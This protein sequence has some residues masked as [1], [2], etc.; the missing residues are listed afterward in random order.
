MP[1]IK[2]EIKHY[3]ATGNLRKQ[4]II[5]FQLSTV[6]AVVN[7]WHEALDVVVVRSRNK[8]GH[9]QTLRLVNGLR[10]QPDAATT[11]YDISNDVMH[12]ELTYF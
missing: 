4:L 1:N 3:Y 7:Q 9:T 11:R 10:R 5:A 8:V 12:P 6:D 2:T